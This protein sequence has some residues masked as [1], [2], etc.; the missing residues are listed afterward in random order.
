MD[1]EP[2]DR[3]KT[4]LKWAEKA[5]NELIIMLCE[6]HMARAQRNAHP[7]SRKIRKA[8]FEH[9]DTNCWGCICIKRESWSKTNA[10]FNWLTRVRSRRDHGTG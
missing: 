7:K 4:S 5:S 8:T 1:R 2:V 3:L 10:T 6:F 9:S